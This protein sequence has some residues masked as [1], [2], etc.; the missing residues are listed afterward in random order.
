MQSFG[1]ESFGDVRRSCTDDINMELGRHTLLLSWDIDVCLSDSLRP[2][3]GVGT[4]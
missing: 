1:D 2:I 4:V 3:A